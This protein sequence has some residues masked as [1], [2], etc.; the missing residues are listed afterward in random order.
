MTAGNEQREVWERRWLGF[1]QRGEQVPLQ[2][3]H[4]NRR[5]P[6][7]IRETACE[8]GTGE[9]RPDQPGSGG[10]GDAVQLARVR[11]GSL[12]RT[13]HQWQETP[14]VVTRGELGHDTAKRAVQLDLAEQLVRQE[15]RACI[16]HRS[17]TFVARGFQGEDAHKKIVVQKTAVP[18]RHEAVIWRALRASPP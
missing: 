8:G 13:L 15:P 1:E 16:E 2:M 6:P 7:R 12:Q 4:S 18:E 14:H 3:V 5:H 17:G 9:Q 10:I 11:G